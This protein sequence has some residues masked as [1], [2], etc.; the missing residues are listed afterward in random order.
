MVQKIRRIVTEV[1]GI[2]PYCEVKYQMSEFVKT[3]QLFFYFVRKYAKLSQYATG[4]LLGK[5][6]STVVHAERC[7]EKFRKIEVNYRESF[8]MIENKIKNNQP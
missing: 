1:T 7:V 2:D 8:D 4:Q 6:H 3:R 5:D